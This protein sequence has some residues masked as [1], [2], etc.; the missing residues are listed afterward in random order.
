MIPRSP[1]SDIYILFRDTLYTAY[2]YLCMYV[3]MYII[4]IF[5]GLV[6]KACSF[7]WAI[8]GRCK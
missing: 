3:R 1:T 6:M 5:F 2:I 8:S 4:T 7:I